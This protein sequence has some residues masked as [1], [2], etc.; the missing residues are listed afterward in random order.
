MSDIKHKNEKAENVVEALS[1]TQNFFENNKKRII[2][3]M[4]A[5]IVIAAAIILYHRFVQIP[6]R[7]EAVAQ[8]F[9]AE[10]NFRAENWEVALNGDGNNL[11]F[12]QLIEEY[13]TRGGEAVY[14]YAGACEMHLGNFQNA[15]NYFE[16]YN[17]KDEIIAA[18]AL[19]CI[20]DAYSNLEQSEKAVSYYLKAA[21]RADNML[22]ANYLMKAATLYESM[23]N[24]AEALK[25]YK[26]IRDKYPQSPEA[27]EI[28]KYISRI[29]N[30]K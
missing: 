7:N 5:V 22:A 16:K 30:A 20:G 27:Y 12:K 17:G 4:G 15:I 24:K 26:L 11:G 6:A 14:F 19:C 3:G 29:E 8:T 28:S 9:V 10:Q 18:R 21:Q 1:K 25:N 13:G 2:Y 23:G